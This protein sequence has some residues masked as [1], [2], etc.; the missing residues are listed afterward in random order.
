MKMRMY[1]VRIA[2]SSGKRLVKI[3]DADQLLA[4]LVN[5]KT[6]PTAIEILTG[7][8]WKSD[9]AIGEVQD[10][11]EAR[12]VVGFEGTRAEVDWML[13]QLAEECTQAGF[14][15]ARQ[16]LPEQVEGLL[17]RLTEFPVSSESP[18]VLKAS[19]LPS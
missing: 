13:G 7:P 18:L 9:V 8:Q 12:L 4:N 16:V 1:A 6:T 5:S 14:S 19:V 10:D 11:I 2:N 15:N 17:N 3:S